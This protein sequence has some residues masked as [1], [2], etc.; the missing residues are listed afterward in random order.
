MDV[1]AG[2]DFKFFLIHGVRFTSQNKALDKGENEF[3]S[4]L[5]FTHRMDGSSEVF[6]KKGRMLMLCIKF[7]IQGKDELCFALLV[8]HCPK[9]KSFRSTQPQK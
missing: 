4:E 6:F 9:R 5:P 8:L 1:L 2:F 7:L 3:L